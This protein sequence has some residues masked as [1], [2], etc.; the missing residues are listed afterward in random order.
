MACACKVN[1]EISF[2][3]KRYGS[4][5]VRSKK[6]NI[7]GIVGLWAREVAAACVAILVV[8][9]VFIYALYTV[10]NSDDGV[11]KLDKVWRFA[12]KHREKE[13]GR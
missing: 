9:F 7:K 8:P 6:S 13:D 1:Q 4:E 3:Q 11:I 2:L 5:N 12:F 10:Y